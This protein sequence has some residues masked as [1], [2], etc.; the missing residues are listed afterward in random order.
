VLRGLPRPAATYPI[1][2]IGMAAFSVFFMQSPSF[3]AHQQ[4]LR[5]GHG[6]SNAETLFGLSRI[7]SD[8]HIRNMLDLATPALLFPAFT[9]ALHE[10]EQSDGLDAFRR[11]DGH[12]LIALD[13]TE[14]FRSN[15]IHCPQCST[16]R[17]SSGKTE[18]YHAMLG[19]TLVAPGH[20]HVLPLEPE[21]VAPQDG[22]EKQDCESRA[23]RRWLTAH[24]RQYAR[25]KPVYLG[26]DLF[27]NQPI[28]EA[29][30]A[31]DGH[32][33][34]VC[35]PAS[36][37]L[38]QE[39]QT[40]VEL[41]AHT[42]RIKRGRHWFTH[43]F[44]WMSGVPLRDGKDAMTV[45]WLEIE[46]RNAAGQVTYR[47]SFITDLPVGR[48]N[49]AELAAC[50]RARWK[51]ENETFNVLKTSGYHLEH[52]F[53]HGQKN[54]A[55]LLVTLNLLAFAFHTVCDLAAALWQTARAKAGSRGQFFRNLAG[56]TTFLI[57]PTWENL[58]KTLAF[59]QPPPRPP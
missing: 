14:Y 54:L 43:H 19:A 23:A 27:S 4:R 52:N 18:Y 24:G 20:N 8:N 56:I 51:I 44:R 10:V 6:R 31:V 16:R 49:V 45:N 11:L 12:V 59:A 22:T 2:D 32:F 35:K 17:R 41:P 39:Y 3:L 15:A 37:L 33:L 5:E 48:D 28:C 42:E 50:G 29:V 38:I 30:R 25:L 46:I 53:G 13:G 40:G 34:F 26:D 9:V 55:A 21:F 58:L 1:A 36:H 7:P 57:F 47:N